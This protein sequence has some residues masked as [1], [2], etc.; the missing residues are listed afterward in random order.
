MFVICYYSW[1]HLIHGAE[2]MSIILLEAANAGEASQGS[3]QLVSVQNT[4]VCH[5][6]RQLSPG[7]RP[8]IKHQTVTKQTKTHTHTHKL[9]LPASILLWRI[10]I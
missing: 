6:K 1:P 8:V 10:N 2:D 9:Q 7:A 4:K 5:A 3:R